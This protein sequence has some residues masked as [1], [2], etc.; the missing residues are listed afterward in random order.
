MK[1]PD[2]AVARLDSAAST[3]RRAIKDFNTNATPCPCCG[4][5]KSEDFEEH[6]L[7]RELTAAADKVERLAREIE[8]KFGSRAGE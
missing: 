6:R 1:N 2:G 8:R 7:H 4:L 3:I 5:N